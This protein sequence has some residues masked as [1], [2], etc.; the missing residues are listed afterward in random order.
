MIT[1]REYFKTEQ[2]EEKGSSPKFDALWKGV[3]WQWYTNNQNKLF[4]HW[5]PNYNWEMNFPLEGYNECLITY[6]MAASSSHAIAPAAYH[7]GW[8]R[9]GGIVSINEIQSS[10]DFKTQWCRRFGGPLFWA[11]YSYLGFRPKSIDG[12]I[13]NYWDLNSIILKSTIYMQWLIHFQRIWC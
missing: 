13:C 8:A 5:S 1:V 10:F 7:E 9:G 6:V 12:Q 4:W 11:H 3:D 2:P